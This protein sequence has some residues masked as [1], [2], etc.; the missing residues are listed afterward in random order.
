[1]PEKRKYF[2]RVDL[3][4]QRNWVPYWQATQLPTQNSV[5]NPESQKNEIFV[6]EDVKHIGGIEK[7]KIKGIYSVEELTA[8]SF[9]ILNFDLELE[10]LGLSL[11][12]LEKRLSILEDEKILGD[13]N[14]RGPILGSY[15]GITRDRKNRK[16]IQI[17][18]QEYHSHGS[19]IPIYDEAGNI[20]P[21][22]LEFTARLSDLRKLYYIKAI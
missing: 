3:I 14:S 9:G 15:G 1:M 6:L 22:F 5:K 7:P 20:K 18:F 4:K 16:E 11:G 19:K 10:Q 12:E 17:R 13:F 8:W 2:S 21:E